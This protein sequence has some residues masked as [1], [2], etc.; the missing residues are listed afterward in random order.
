MGAHVMHAF[1]FQECMNWRRNILAT[2]H[3]T[4][5][6]ASYNSFQIIIL[7]LSWQ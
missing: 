7:V 1:V 3:V 4:F 5:F 2:F 6:L